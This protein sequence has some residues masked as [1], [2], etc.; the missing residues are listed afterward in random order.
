M[1]RLAAA[2]FFLSLAT[3]GCAQETST[4]AAAASPA[5]P[6]GE[7]EA[8]A[9]AA[10]PETATPDQAESEATAA[11]ESGD[12]AATDERSD[13]SL[14]RL[15]AL[16]ASQQLPSGRW[17]PGVHYRPIVPAQPT[18]AQ[19][20][21]VEVLE[22]F[23]YGCPHCFALEPYLASWQ[24]N[25]PEAAELVKMP[26]MWG[27][28][29]QAQARLYYTL[30]ALDRS[31]L[32]QKVFQLAQRDRAWPAAGRGGTI[33]DARTKQQ[34][35]EFAKA[36]GISEAEF[37]RAYDDFSVA[38][39]LERAQKLTESYNVDGVP[40]FVVA[41]KYKTDV[42]MAGG[43]KELMQLLSDLAASEAKR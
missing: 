3:A 27:P 18:Y 31:D 4:P 2:I 35:I 24:K 32:H 29:H 6:A 8:P 33:D 7:A 43:Q 38:N 5:A 16:P 15:A 22:I 25:K 21:K 39:N 41:G 36:N 20:G 30:E 13:V 28:A 19:P 26:V 1:I 37:N 40:F 12:D 11:Q 17:K 14:E 10:V 23:W 34:M 42:G 9:P